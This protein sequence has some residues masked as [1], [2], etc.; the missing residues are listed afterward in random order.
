M[1]PLVKLFKTFISLVKARIKLLFFNVVF[2]CTKQEKAFLC[3]HFATDESL[4]LLLL[5]ISPVILL[6]QRSVDVQPLCVFKK[7]MSS[8]CLTISFPFY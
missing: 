3:L 4:T 1:F 2:I 8:V 7:T 6:T 5:Q